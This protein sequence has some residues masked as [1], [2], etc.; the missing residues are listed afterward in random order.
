MREAT[1]R[2][3]QMDT[4]NPQNMEVVLQQRN[5]QPTKDRKEVLVSLPSSKNNQNKKF[6]NL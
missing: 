1:D 3:G 5:K 2:V 6:G 4:S